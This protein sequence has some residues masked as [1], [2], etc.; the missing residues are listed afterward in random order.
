MR[1]GRVRSR[2]TIPTLQFRTPHSAFRILVLLAACTPV[3]TRP[4]FRPFPRALTAI[5][6]ARPDKVVTVLDSLVAAERLGVARSSRLDGYLETTWYD[7]ARKTSFPG[8]GDVPDFANTVKVRCWADPYVP[9][10]SQVTIEPVYRPRYD[11]SRTERDLE[12]V[13]PQD[14]EGY[15]IAERLLGGLKKRLGSP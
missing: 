5:V 9:G 8:T 3:T 14:H 1:N 6:N 15:K 12:V 7:V 2:A 11:P 10:Q 13:V 4:D